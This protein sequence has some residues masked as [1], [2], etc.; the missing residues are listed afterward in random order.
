M[1]LGVGLLMMVALS[2]YIYYAL[3][4]REESPVSREE[5]G[6][7]IL[8]SLLTGTVSAVLVYGVLLLRLQTIYPPVSGVDMGEPP[9]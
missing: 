6:Y 5:L 1:I 8:C 3:M 2:A 7:V 9:F 4:H